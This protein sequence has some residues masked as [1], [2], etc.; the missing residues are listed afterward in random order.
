[1]LQMEFVWVPM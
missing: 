1:V